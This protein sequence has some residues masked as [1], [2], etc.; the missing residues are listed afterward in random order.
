MDNSRKWK[1]LRLSDQVFQCQL[2]HILEHVENFG[3]MLNPTMKNHEE[4]ERNCIQ[5]GPFSK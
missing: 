4:I 3:V 1:S 2:M 5:C